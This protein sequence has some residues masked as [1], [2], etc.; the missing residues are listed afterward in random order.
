MDEW[1][2][3]HAPDA[4][5]ATRNR[6]EHESTSGRGRVVRQPQVARESPGSFTG[7]PRDF[8]SKVRGSGIRS[9][10]LD[11]ALG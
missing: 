8:K 1:D 5:S 9:R 2:E 4:S 6:R 3:G 11:L 10:S 7:D